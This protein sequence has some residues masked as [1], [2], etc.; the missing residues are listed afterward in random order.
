MRRT[1]LLAAAVGLGVLLAPLQ[2]SAQTVYPTGTTIW[3]QGRTF[4]GYTLFAERGGTVVLIDMDGTVVNTWVSPRSGHSLDNVEPLPGGR[5]LALDREN[6]IARRRGVVE[7]DYDGNPLWWY[8]VPAGQPPSTGFHHDTT[9]LRNGNTLVLGSQRLT[10]TPVSPLE[11]EDDFLIELDANGQ[12]VWGWETWRHYDELGLSATQKAIIS[13]MGGDWAHTNTVQEIPP[14]NH[15]Q[16]EFA[17]GNI[18]TCIRYLNTIAIIDKTTGQIVWRDGPEPDH[19]THGA[20][21]PYMIEQGLPGAGNILVFD[22]G[23]GTG[24]C[25]EH[26][27]PGFSRVIEIDPVTKQIVWLYMESVNFWSNIFSNAQRLPNGNTFIC[28]GA[29]GR[30]FEVDPS[31]EVVWEYMSPYIYPIGQHGM[32]GRTYRAFRLPYD[33][34][35]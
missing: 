12:I 7:M 34:K 28:S 22:N 27:A 3:Q 23:S 10:G 1:F 9:R 5:I 29:R 20:H 13:E 33:W 35:P 31:G 19:L 8:A 4:D 24:Y 25:H 30:L 16:P 32:T 21:M 6:P 2:L 14:N 26:R 11:I 15:I 17:E 18:I